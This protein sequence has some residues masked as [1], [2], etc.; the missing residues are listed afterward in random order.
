M[1]AALVAG[2]CREAVAPPPT[3][4]LTTTTSV[5]T[6]TAA[7]TTVAPTPLPTSP[8]TTE[9]PRVAEVVAAVE[10]YRQVLVAALVSGG[11]T[12]DELETVAGQELARTISRN[13]ER[14]QAEGRTVEGSFDGSVVDVELSNNVAIVTDCSLDALAAYSSDGGV[15][16]P[17]DDR[18]Y[19]RIYMLSA[20]DRGWIVDD[21]HFLGGEPQECDL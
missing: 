18:A 12:L 5:V 2:G 6:T 1:V 13:V 16:V 10:G 17:P 20:T 15:V 14:S 9:D 21:V 7:P 4:S 8:A 3:L 19:L 11:V